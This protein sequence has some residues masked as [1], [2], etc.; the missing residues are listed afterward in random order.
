[1][2]SLYLRVVPASDMSFVK[3]PVRLA[4]HHLCCYIT[5]WV[6]LY[7]FAFTMAF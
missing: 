2:W 6:P 1:M 5:L 4:K 7:S 3:V